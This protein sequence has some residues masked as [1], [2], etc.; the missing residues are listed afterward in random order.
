M[1]VT[2]INETDTS[3]IGQ[4]DNEILQRLLNVLVT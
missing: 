1:L 2:V 3:F 4:L